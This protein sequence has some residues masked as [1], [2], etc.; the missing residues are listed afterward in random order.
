MCGSRFSFSLC[1]LKMVVSVLILI[2]K[3]R[4][5]SPLETKKEEEES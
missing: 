2:K 4:V 3:R 5:L 1:Y